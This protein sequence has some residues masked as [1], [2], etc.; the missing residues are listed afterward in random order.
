[1]LLLVICQTPFCK[2]AFLT[3]GLTH[4][5]LLQDSRPRIPKLW[6]PRLR[7]AAVCVHYFGSPGG[8]QFSK[9]RIEYA[10]HRRDILCRNS[11][12]PPTIH[13]HHAVPRGQSTN[14]HVDATTESPGHHVLTKVFLREALADGPHTKSPICAL[15]RRQHQCYLPLLPSIVPFDFVASCSR[16]STGSSIC[17][18]RALRELDPATNLCT[19]FPWTSQFP[20]TFFWV[21]ILQYFQLLRHV[22][23]KFY[24]GMAHQRVLDILRASEAQIHHFVAWPR[25]KGELHSGHTLP[26]PLD[27]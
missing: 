9:H 27:L 18:R 16:V 10:V 19:T 2:S 6:L 21:S 5:S 4:S 25:M 20:K 24:L 14:H 22:F 12:G 13:M 3:S 15:R 26:P 11:T 17:S 7:M 8:L 1:M 23:Q